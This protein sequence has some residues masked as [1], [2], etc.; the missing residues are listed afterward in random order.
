MGTDSARDIRNRAFL[1][2]CHVAKLS[3]SFA[4]RPGF[5]CVADQL[6]T[7]GTAIGANLEEAKAGSSRREFIRYVEIA[8]REARE[9][10][11]WLR[12]CHALSMGP[13][14]EVQSLQF[15]ADQIIRILTAITINTKR[16]MAEG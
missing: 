4:S 12:L 9:S 7:S 3:L 2:G 6:F 13:A 14:T 10:L 15:E 5:R 11:Y 8:L 1:F 16:R